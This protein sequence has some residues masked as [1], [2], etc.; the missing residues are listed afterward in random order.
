MNAWWCAGSLSL[1]LVAQIASAQVPPAP[2][3]SD[4][5]KTVVHGKGGAQAEQRRLDERVPGFATAIAL[6]DEAKGASS[7]AL[8]T[9]LSRSV[10]LTLRSVGGLGQFS[11]VSMR[12]SSPQQ[13]QLFVDGVPLNQSMGGLV[14]LSAMPLD[15]FGRIDVYRG[16]VPIRYGGG[17]I[18][19]A[20]DLIS[21]PSGRPGVEAFLGMGSFGAR[22]ARLAARAGK[23]G[24]AWSASLGITGARGNYPFYDDKGFPD[25]PALAGTSRRQNNDYQRFFGRV[26]WAG[27]WGPW[28]AR[29]TQMFLAKEQGV[30]GVSTVRDN[31]SRLKTLGLRT[32]LLARRKLFN[33]EGHVEIVSGIGAEQFHFNNPSGVDLGLNNQIGRNVDVY[34]SPRLRWPWRAHAFVFTGDARGELSEVNERALPS[35]RGD[36]QRYR[37]SGGVG[38]EAEL[39]FWENLLLVVPAVR[40]DLAKSGFKV[41]QGAGELNDGGADR[42]NWGVSPRVAARVNVVEGLSLRTSLGRSFRLP[43]LMELFGNRGTMRG[44]PGLHPE[45][46]TSVDL[47]MVYDKP[48]LWKH[49]VYGQLVGFYG[50]REHLIQWR[51]TGRTVVPENVPGGAQLGGV[52]LRWDIAHAREFWGLRGNYTWLVTRNGD[53]AL[54]RH[55]KPLPGRPTHEMYWEARVGGDVPCAGKP[56]RGEVFG[57]QEFISQTFLDFAGRE[58]V[59]PRWLHGVGLRA[60][61]GQWLMFTLEMRNVFDVRTG[62]WN[63]PFFADRRTAIGDFAGFPLPGRSLWA[64]L[65]FDFD[66]AEGQAL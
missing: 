28:R 56:L 60:N 20:I 14:D 25:I 58:G 48:D 27:H 61:W 5:M 4:E 49:H 11:A 51:S 66:V 36:A 40:V 43:T 15:G 57:S 16:H 1:L 52:E 42:F 18:G 33:E 6:A 9:L 63:S 37:G 8:P 59:P 23:P 17:A 46:G 3:P 7:D 55:G 31:T 2:A 44:N 34:L 22:E 65:R 12:G 64:S 39:R 62:V 35:P 45:T 54:A 30:P 32:A 47:G 41:P 24:N 29:V 21:A 50:W 13:V 26:G 10:G 19:G 53:P 38:A